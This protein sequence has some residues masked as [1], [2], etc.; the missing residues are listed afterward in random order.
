MTIGGELN[1][2]SEAC[3]EVAHKRDAGNRRPERSPTCHETISFES[4]S[5]AGPRRPHVAS[6]TALVFWHIFRFAVEL[7]IPSH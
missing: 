1:A 6:V 4:A 3:P 2:V 5:T 7:D